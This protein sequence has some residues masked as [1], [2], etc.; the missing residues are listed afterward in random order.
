MVTGQLTLH[1]VTRSI[2]VPVTVRLEGNTLIATGRFPVK[3]TEYGI[4]PVSVGG[5]VSVKDAV[6]VSFTIVGR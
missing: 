4:R 1:N 6:N 3:Q 2:I 5:V